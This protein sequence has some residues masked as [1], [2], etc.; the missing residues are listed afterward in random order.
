MAKHPKAPQPPH[1]VIVVNATGR[2]KVKQHL[3]R[4]KQQPPIVAANDQAGAP[5]VAW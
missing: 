2:K 4:V 3:R 5:P 1:R